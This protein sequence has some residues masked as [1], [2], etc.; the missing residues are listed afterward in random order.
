MELKQFIKAAIT[1]ISEAISELQEELDNGAII[2]PQEET[3]NL[4]EHIEINDKFSRIE[5]LNFDVAVTASESTGASGGAKAGISVFGAKINGE[6]SAKSEHASR[7][8]FSIPVVFPTATVTND[9]PDEDERLNQV[10]G[11][12]DKAS[13]RNHSYYD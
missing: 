6:T 2:N 11:Q 4:N 10:Y 9:S 5:R 7:L 13:G 12:L 8:T 3:G 1:D